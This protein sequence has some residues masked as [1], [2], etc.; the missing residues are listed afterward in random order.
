MVALPEPTTQLHRFAV[1]AEARLRLAFP[2]PMFEFA[3][4]SALPSK[5]EFDRLTRRKPFIGLAWAGFKAAEK[6]GRN[7][8]GNL[9]WILLLVVDNPDTRRRFAGDNRGVGIW[10]M[11]SA[12]S[13]LL[14]GWTFDGLGT[15]DVTQADTVVRDDWGDETTA[16]A[17][18]G[19]TV[20]M[21]PDASFAAGEL[22][23]FLRLHCAWLSPAQDGSA[24]MPADLINVRG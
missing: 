4:M 14:H 3:I 23:D 16:I 19:L 11:F 15:V 13:H 17:A 22:D 1:A 8:R 10:G 21:H 6:T 5:A 12:A 18:L 9:D 7:L 2:E 20:P 24:S